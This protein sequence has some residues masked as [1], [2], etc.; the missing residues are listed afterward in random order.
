MVEEEAEEVEEEEEDS[1]MKDKV[2]KPQLKDKMSFHRMKSLHRF[3][4]I[5]QSS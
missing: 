5:F 4:S 2:K 1:M 3:S